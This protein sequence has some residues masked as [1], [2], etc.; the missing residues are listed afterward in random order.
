MIQLDDPKSKVREVQGAH[1][2]GV[3]GPKTIQIFEGPQDDIEA[4]YALLGC[5]ADHWPGL[6][7]V[8]LVPPKKSWMGSNDWRLV[9]AW[10]QV[11]SPAIEPEPGYAP[12]AAPAARSAVGE[13]KVITR[14]YTTH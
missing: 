9:T 5:D 2:I 10:R 14:N 12:V 4:L 7:G 8:L 3:T 6:A 1:M 13:V 11:A